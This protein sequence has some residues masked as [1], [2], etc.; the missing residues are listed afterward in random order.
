MKKINCGLIVSDFDST[1]TT[2]EHTVPEN[3]KR[4][5][6]EYVAAGGIFAV[7]TGRMLRSILPEVRSL[8]LKGVVVAYQG[9]VIADIESG[10]LIKKGGFTAAEAREIC[11]A[12]EQLNAYINVYADERLYTNIP[13]NNK[14]LKL[15]EDITKVEAECVLSPL[16]EFV[17]KNDLF[18]Q[19]TASLVSPRE[20][21]NLYE[22]L[23]E[24]LG[25]KYDVTCSADVLVEVSPKADNKGSALE[26]LAKHYGVPLE[27]TVAVGDNLND[28]SMIKAAKTGVAVGNAVPELKAAADFVSVT[29][30]E[31]A[32]AQIIEKFGF[33]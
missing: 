14:Y 24:K 26:F 31:G 28:I 21:K 30:N 18:C 9:T 4:A 27:K 5:I 17:Y 33:V 16:S 29:N 20:R 7:C 2:D 15:Y 8:G 13:R 3:V 25:G 10:Q 6:S 23:N 12:L 19:K 1:L 22:K 32:L 11:L